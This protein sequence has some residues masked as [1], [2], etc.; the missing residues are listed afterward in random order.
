M[1]AALII[2]AVLGLASIPALAW[3]L[4]QHEARLAEWEDES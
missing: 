3:I 4:C 2:F 1:S